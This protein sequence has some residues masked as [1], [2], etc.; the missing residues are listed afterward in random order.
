MQG[1]SL[2]SEPAGK[3]GWVPRSFLFCLCVCLFLSL[4]LFVSLS[5][6]VSLCE[7]TLSPFPSESRLPHLPSAKARAL[8]RRLNASL[9]PHICGVIVSYDHTVLRQ[10]IVTGRG[11]PCGRTASAGLGP[12]GL[13]WASWPRRGPVCSFGLFRPWQQ[14]GP[15]PRPSPPPPPCQ[16]CSFCAKRKMPLGRVSRKCQCLQNPDPRFI[17]SFIQQ[18]DYRA[19]TRCQAMFQALRPKP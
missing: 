4:S 17:H 6:S 3:P 9:Q 5:L 2:P 14:P 12:A 19:P 8:T 13:S 1:V 11:P 10:I 16:T 15:A 7:V 18:I